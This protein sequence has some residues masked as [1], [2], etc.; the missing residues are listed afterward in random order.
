MFNADITQSN[1]NR[2]DDVKYFFKK[3]KLG[4]SGAEFW[5]GANEFTVWL[6]THCPQNETI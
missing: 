4:T 2:M 6:S 3:K 5:K 1:T